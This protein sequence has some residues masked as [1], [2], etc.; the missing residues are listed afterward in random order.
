MITRTDLLGGDFPAGVILHNGG[1]DGG[2]AGAGVAA[3]DE[4]VAGGFDVELVFAGGDGGQD[5]GL[6]VVDVLVGGGRGEAGLDCLVD[7]EDEKD[8]EKGGE[9]LEEGGLFVAPRQDEVLPQQG[10]ILLRDQGYAAIQLHGRDERRPFFC[11]FPMPRTAG[12]GGESMEGEAF[13]FGLRRGRRLLE[14]AIYK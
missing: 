11:L 3:P 7:A 4:I 12:G 8:E 2:D 13:H 5:E 9:E 6:G 14:G 1:D 10:R